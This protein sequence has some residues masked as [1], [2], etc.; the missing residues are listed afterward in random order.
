V[1]WRYWKVSIGDEKQLGINGCLSRKSETAMP[2]MNTISLSSVDKFFNLIQ[3]KGGKI[4]M[5]KTAIPGDGW[6][7]TCQDTEGNIF[8]IT[9][10]NK[11]AN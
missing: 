5:P 4:L 9:E 7:S 6:F 8:R 10:E 11:M 2:T 3:N 1:L